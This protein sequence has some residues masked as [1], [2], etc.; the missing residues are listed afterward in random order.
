MTVVLLLT[1]Y[2]NRHFISHPMEG[3]SCLGYHDCLKLV[4]RDNV[5]VSDVV[6]CTPNDNIM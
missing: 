1:E 6:I 2:S 4:T 3:N 5:F